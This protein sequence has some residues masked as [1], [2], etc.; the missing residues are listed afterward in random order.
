MEAKTRKGIAGK[1]AN[2]GKVVRMRRDCYIMWGLLVF[3][4]I[5]FY[6]IS[7]FVADH[8]IDGFDRVVAVWVQSIR[9]DRFTQLA[10]VLAAVGAPRLAVRAAVGL[11]V[12]GLVAVFCL[13]RQQ[14]RALAPQ[15]MVFATVNIAAFYSNNWLKHYFH[16]TRPTDHIM[17]Y[18]YPSGHAMAAFAL[19]VTAACLLW[20]NIP[21]K[22][23]RVAVAVLC[24]LLTLL[25]GLSRVYLNV[26]YPSDII[27]GYF[28]SGG[29]LLAVVLLYRWRRWRLAADQ[30]HR[31]YL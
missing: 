8:S 6:I 19:Y 26:H 13:R 15:F 24:S 23:G 9:S 30:Q 18:S 1:S 14:F 25:V 20:E 22:A 12:A 2:N 3:C 31:T 28:V 17:S 10:G 29:I 7:L 5:G 16:R 4:A 21:S 27:G 11:A